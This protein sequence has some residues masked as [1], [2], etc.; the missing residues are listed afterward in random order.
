MRPAR[1]SDISCYRY[2]DKILEGCD[3][4]KGNDSTRERERVR[5]GLSY[6]SGEISDTLY[7]RAADRGRDK[8]A[9]RESVSEVGYASDLWVWLPS[10]TIR[11]RRDFVW[12]NR[13]PPRLFSRVAHPLATPSRSSSTCSARLASS[14]PPSPP[15]GRSRIELSH[16]QPVSVHCLLPALHYIPVL[17]SRSSSIYRCNFGFINV[18]PDSPPI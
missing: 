10:C 9:G 8:K 14:S 6:L 17:T 12:V 5:N 11:A 7:Y 1:W 3:N 18:A 2:R 16:S 4:Y 13:D 15:L